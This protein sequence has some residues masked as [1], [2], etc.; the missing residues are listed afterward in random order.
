MGDIPILFLRTGGRSRFVAG[1]FRD[2]ALN[3]QR[4]A[5]I[6]ET[7]HRIDFDQTFAVRGDIF[8]W[9]FD[10]HPASGDSLQTVEIGNITFFGFQ[11]IFSVNYFIY[12]GKG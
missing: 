11:H 2:P 6:A 7:F 9:E 4:F 1:I 10:D 3:D 8:T 5:G 12:F